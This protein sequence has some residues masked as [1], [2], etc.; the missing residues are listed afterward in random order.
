ME[1]RSFYL[2][3]FPLCC[4]IPVEGFCPSPSIFA[5]KLVCGRRRSSFS[6]LGSATVS[7]SNCVMTETSW[8]SF[9]TVSMCLPL[10]TLSHFPLNVGFLSFLTLGD[11]S[12]FHNI[13]LETLK[14][15][16]LIIWSIWSFTAVFNCEQFGFPLFRAVSWS[17]KANTV[18]SWAEFC[19]FDLYNPSR[20]T[21][22]GI[23]LPD[24]SAWSHLTSKSWTSTVCK[25]T[26]N[27]SESPCA[28]CIGSGCTEILIDHV[29]NWSSSW[30]W[31][32][33]LST[34]L[35]DTYSF[36]EEYL[37]VEE[38]VW[39]RRNHRIKHIEVQG[40]R[41]APWSIAMSQVRQL[42]LQSQLLWCP[43]HSDLKIWLFLY[44]PHSWS[45]LSPALKI[46]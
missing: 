35:F 46:P 4:L 44:I 41:F 36:S 6:S 11:W 9:G 32:V 37:R 13:A 23:S 12:S 39:C 30:D 31:V 29:R 18:W 5:F 42:S 10:K 25:L 20:S 38:L 1:F 33:F 16:V 3:S 17:Y 24:S 27:E 40:N 26:V 2:K 7:R 15:R 34:L 43:V 45:W 8:V 28:A 22:E 19:S 21:S 14:F